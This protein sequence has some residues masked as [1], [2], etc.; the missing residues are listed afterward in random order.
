MKHL[1]P[2]IL[3]MLLMASQSLASGEPRP[4]TAVVI[5]VPDGGVV[6]MGGF[7]PVPCPPP[8]PRR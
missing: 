6:Q 1:I 2:A 7:P 4:G 3:A 8:G 5:W